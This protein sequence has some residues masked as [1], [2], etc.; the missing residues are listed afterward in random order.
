MSNIKFRENQRKEFEE[1]R[2][3][4]EER[5]AELNVNKLRYL[6]SCVWP[7][8]FFKQSILVIA[9]NVYIFTYIISTFPI[10]KTKS[11]C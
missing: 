7:C 10:P 1:Q 11:E 5:L 9:Q 3:D 4:Y 2:K 8:R 6:S